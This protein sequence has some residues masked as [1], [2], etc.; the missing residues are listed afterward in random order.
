[1][2]RAVLDRPGVLHLHG[3][4]GFGQVLLA[5]AGDVARAHRPL[6][7]DPGAASVDQPLPVG[8]AA[9]AHGPRMPDRAGRA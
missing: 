8:P 5:R 6:G 2:H 9:L 4:L 7:A 3:A 1:L